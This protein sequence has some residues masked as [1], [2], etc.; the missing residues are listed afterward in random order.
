MRN[1]DS[2]EMELAIEMELKDTVMYEESKEY[3]EWW[4]NQ[5]KKDMKNFGITCSYALHPSPI[6]N[7]QK[8]YYKST[9]TTRTTTSSNT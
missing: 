3:Y 6:P 4:I 5:D 8:Y 2:R 9:S 7:E 1:I